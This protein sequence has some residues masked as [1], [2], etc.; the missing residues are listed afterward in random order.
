MSTAYENLPAARFAIRYPDRTLVCSIDDELPA[1]VADPVLLRRVLDNLLDNA[2]KFSEKPHAIELEGKFEAAPPSLVIGVRDRGV[3]IA[4]GDVD[5]IFEPFFRGDRSRTRATG[6]VGLGL[7]IARR[8]VEAH[9]GSLGVESSRA[10]GTG[11]RFWVKVPAKSA[12][13]K[14][15]DRNESRAARP[16]TTGA[17]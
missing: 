14:K 15:Q 3:G 2:A 11:T 8:I 7:A 1:L 13:T 6:G 12:A 16:V 9:S 17:L 4:A 5:R 10:E